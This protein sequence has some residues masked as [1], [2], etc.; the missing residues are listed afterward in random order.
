MNLFDETISGRVNLP[1]SGTINIH[2]RIPKQT[3]YLKEYKIQINSTNTGILYVDVPFLNSHNLVDG[4]DYMSRLPLLVDQ[5]SSSTIVSCNIPIDISGTIEPSFPM[6]VYKRDGTLASDI[7]LVG[8][9]L[10]FSCKI[11]EINN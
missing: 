7:S 6:K 9:T 2:T 11:G 3:I 1:Y 10:Q 5:T 4:V 8:V